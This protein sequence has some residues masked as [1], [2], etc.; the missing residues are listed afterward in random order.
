M[1][2]LE[3]RVRAYWAPRGDLSAIDRD[4]RK[5]GLD[6]AC[7]AP[8][9]LAV[10]DQ[11]HAGLDQG[12][13][14]LCG[15][16]GITPGCRVIDLGAGLGGTARQLARDLDCRAEAIDLSPEL[17]AAG[18]ELTRRMGL[19]S[20]VVHRCCGFSDLRAEGG[21]DVALIQFVDMQVRDKGV[22]YRA[23]HES[24]APGGRV[25]WHDWLAGD[26]GAPFYPMFW[27]RDGDCSFPIRRDEFTFALGQAGLDLA[28]LET[29]DD[30]TVGWFERSREGI[31][32]V[33][34][35]IDRSTEE[36]AR[37]AARLVRL[38]E[39]VDNALGN[40]RDQRLVPFFAEAVPSKR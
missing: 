34:G 10:H 36:G 20:R 16:A 3:A 6:P 11:L 25:I 15:W 21:F 19:A 38:L 26:G 28:R 12:T 5:K 35:R 24:L 17:T 18:A 22:L 4:L 39:E 27:S 13:A 2:D 7:P 9:S 8:A 31:H 37:R 1:D 40:I 14:A 33:L 29:I 30:L 32:K 23:A